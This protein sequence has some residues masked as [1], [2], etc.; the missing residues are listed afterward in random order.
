MGNHAILIVAVRPD[1][2]VLACD[3]KMANPPALAPAA[4]SIWTP[5][6]ARR[7]VMIKT[8]AMN[9][10][11]IRASRSTRISPLRD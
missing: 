11:N 8:T 3:N 4:I 5:R 6:D 7:I 2:T 9:G 1:S 10:K